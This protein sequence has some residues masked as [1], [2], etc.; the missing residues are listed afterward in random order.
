MGKK[1]RKFKTPEV[2]TTQPVM[3]VGGKK[4]RAMVEVE[5]SVN[6]NWRGPPAVLN[7]PKKV[8]QME[9]R[10]TQTQPTGSGGGTFSL[11]KA[12]MASV[13]D[14]VTGSVAGL[15]PFA[16]AAAA[17][18][19][20]PLINPPQRVNSL[21]SSISTSVAKPYYIRDA[22]FDVA[23]GAADGKQ[24]M[25]GSILIC[26]SRN[27]LRS[28]IQY[29]VNPASNPGAG[30]DPP[31]GCYEGVFY[32]VNK[33]GSPSFNLTL[34]TVATGGQIDLPI[35]WAQDAHV[36]DAA[37]F[38]PHSERLYAGYHEGKHGVWIDATSGRPAIVK[39]LGDS[40]DCKGVV[41]ILSGNSWVPYDDWSTS[42]ATGNTQFTY[43]GYYAFT[44]FENTCTTLQM[45]M[46]VA[47][48]SFGHWAL[49]YMESKQDSL[50]MVRT[51]ALSLM[52]S[53]AASALHA[54]GVIAGV[55]LKPGQAWMD[56]IG[57][58]DNPVTEVLKTTGGEGATEKPL[59]KG[60]YGFHKPVNQHALVETSLSRSN[61]YGVVDYVAPLV[62]QDG[63]LAIAATTVSVDGL[64]PGGDGFLTA[65][66]AVE[67]ASPDPWYGSMVPEGSIHNFEEALTLVKTIPQ[68]H[69]NP[70]HVRDIMSFL[71]G[72]GVKALKI[73]PAFMRF[74][75]Q[76]GK[77]S[78]EVASSVSQIAALAGV[79]V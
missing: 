16:K 8:Q 11:S 42:S 30:A 64:Y 52:W 6:P 62:D 45:K 61:K 39:Y 5:P 2:I 73:A 67:F 21:Y 9:M 40:G 59:K 25:N 28:L 44:I 63:W 69:E 66:W 72:V 17:S 27:P 71:R 46:I 20:L 43:S 49:P 34:P 65:C 60:M 4:K 38:H 76:I 57:P 36:G 56:L 10:L 3:V 7:V 41:Y 31:V 13:A 47:S 14:V 22:K 77:V 53:N 29:Q 48:S 33:I 50:P 15:S 37:Y 18:M 55:Q 51:T 26:A 70:L 32:F 23:N 24:L 12:R 75:E 19:C 35:V 79:L 78:P 74:L 58:S 54:E 68:W 1:S